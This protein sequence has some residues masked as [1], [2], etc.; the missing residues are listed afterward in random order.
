LARAGRGILAPKADACQGV[1]GRGAAREIIISAIEHRVIF[2]TPLAEYL[3]E[4]LV[5]GRVGLVGD[6]AHVASPMVGAGVSSGLQDGTAFIE[7]VSRSGGTKAH[8]GTQALRLYDKARLAPNRRRVLESLAET[9]DL[10]R[11]TETQ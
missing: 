4:R 11:S 10:L 8:A 1:A 6:A 2:G 7:A 3:P 5:A 9:Q